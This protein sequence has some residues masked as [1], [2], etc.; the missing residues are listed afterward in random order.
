VPGVVRVAEN[1]GAALYMV[2]D[3]GGAPLPVTRAPDRELPPTVRALTMMPAVDTAAARAVAVDDQGG[4]VVLPDGS[5]FELDPVGRPK[6]LV[7]TLP[8]PAVSVARRTGTVW[9]SCGDG[10]FWLQDGR[11]WRPMAAVDG[12]LNLTAGRDLWAWGSSGLWRLRGSSWQQ[13]SRGPV[14]AAAALG[15]TIA[16]TNGREVWTLRGAVQR[17]VG[18]PLEQVR[19]LAWEGTALWALAGDGL[20]RSGGSVLPWR[21]SLSGIGGVSAMAG[22]VDRIWLVLDDGTLVQQARARCSSP[23]VG[24]ETGELDEP[25][26]VAVSDAGWFVVADTG[27][28]RVVWF[29]LAGTCLASVGEEGSV[30]GAFSEPTGI[31]LGPDGTLA[32]TDTWNGRIQLLRPDGIVQVVGSELYGPRDVLWIPDGS[33]LVADTGNRLLLRYRPPRWEKEEII[34]LPGPVVGLEWVNGLAAVAVPFAGEVALV[35][36]ASK[37]EVRRLPVPGW[38]QGQQQEGYLALLPSG[39]LLASAPRTGELWRLDPSGGEPVRAAGDVPGIT[40]FEILPGGEILAAITPQHQ[41]V[42]ISLE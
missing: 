10:S 40:A 17:S 29:T 25:R 21:Q 33:L 15:E 41:L 2:L 31:S 20:Y 27:H 18:V 36:I 3:D 9:A 24:G 42:K 7:A 37:S 26:G 1:D 16:A 4:T 28:D 32:V 22:S 5:L 30:P 38:E 12:A 6:P 8:C 39:E 23:F 13:V 14:A 19:A 34:R 35:D 11:V